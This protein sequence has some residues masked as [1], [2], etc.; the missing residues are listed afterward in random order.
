MEMLDRGIAQKR[1]D[2]QAPDVDLQAGA[3]DLPP[4]WKEIIDAGWISYRRNDPGWPQKRAEWVALGPEAEKIL[5]ENLIRY[6]VVAWDH[7]S[8]RE[9]RR[10]EGQLLDFAPLASQYL[11]EAIAGGYGDD[12]TRNIAGEL[13]ARMGAGA[14]P[15]IER[16]WAGAA[17]VGRRFLARSLK[18]MQVPQ[19]IPL[20]VKVARGSEP[21]E[22]RIEAIQGLGDLRTPRAVPALLVCLRDDDVSVRKFAARCIAL[23]GDSSFPV[24]RGLIGCME[25][26]LRDTQLD[27]VRRCNDSLRRLTGQAFRAD[28]RVWKAWIERRER[29]G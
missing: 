18:K 24:L 28:P 6:F 7:G 25:L 12:V 22:T 11:T 9:V 14:V 10:A 20:L 21:W 26:S 19:A 3:E 23:T 2:G 15:G 16:A 17:P 8:E 4:G 5:V 29:S 27:T 1:R 13:L